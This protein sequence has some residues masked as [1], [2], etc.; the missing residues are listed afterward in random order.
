MEGHR[1]VVVHGPLNLINM[2]DFWRDIHSSKASGSEL[3]I[4]ESISYRAT[5]PLYA[6]EKYQIVLEEGE[7]TVKVNIYGPDGTPA[8]KADIQGP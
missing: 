8:M 1:N 7:G 6:D 3:A 4:P 2:L 5:S